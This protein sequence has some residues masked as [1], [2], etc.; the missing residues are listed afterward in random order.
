MC[1]FEVI[2]V[3][4]TLSKGGDQD[5]S[6]RRGQDHLCIVIINTLTHEKEMC[7]DLVKI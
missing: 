2:Q 4:R 6:D 7:V 1:W 5:E 3:M